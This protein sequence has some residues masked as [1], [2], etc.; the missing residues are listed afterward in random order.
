MEQAKVG[1]LPWKDPDVAVEKLSLPHAEMYSLTLRIICFKRKLKLI[2]W[3]QNSE[4]HGVFKLNK[5]MFL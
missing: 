5:L 4:F 2:S 1:A 3:C